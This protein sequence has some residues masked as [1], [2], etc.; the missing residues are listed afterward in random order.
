[1]LYVIDEKDTH[2]LLPNLLLI[3]PCLF[4]S[5]TNVE[6]ADVHFSVSYLTFSLYNVVF[7]EQFLFPVS[8]VTLSLSLLLFMLVTLVQVTKIEIH[9]LA[10]S[11]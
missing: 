11:V 8:S 2:A 10:L 5:S 6:H 4:F 7:A 9:K 3:S 1:M